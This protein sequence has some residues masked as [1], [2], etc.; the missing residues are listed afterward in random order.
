MKKCCYTMYY[1][2]VHFVCVSLSSSRNRIWGDYGGKFEG[3]E[4]ICESR[5]ETTER[6]RHHEEETSERET[7]A[8]QVSH[9]SHREDCQGKEVR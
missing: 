6:D 9:L 1:V 3:W 5:Q 7:G 8:N 4:R 2:L